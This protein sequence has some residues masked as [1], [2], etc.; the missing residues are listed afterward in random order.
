M[1]ERSRVWIPAGA[2][3]EFSSPGSTLSRYPF[4]PRVTAVARKRSR[5]FCQKCRWQVTDKHAYTFRMWLCMKWHG[6]W[7]YGVH[8]TRRDGNSFMYMTWHR[9]CQ[10]CNYTT[11]VDIQKRRYE[12]L[13]TQVLRIICERSESARERR[14]ALYRSNHHQHRDIGSQWKEQGTNR[15]NIMSPTPLNNQPAGRILWPLTCIKVHAT[16]GRDSYRVKHNG[17][18]CSLWVHEA[19]IVS[20]WPCIPC[21]IIERLVNSSRSSFR[22]K[23][24]FV[25]FK[26]TILPRLNFACVWSKLKEHD[27]Q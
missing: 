23:Q 12:K 15:R 3:G 17:P 9:P 4:H 14:T 16:L 10:R 20:V 8:R 24:L 5:S 1:I 19:S 25:S 21:I 11:L 2:A 6:A 27:L 22:V 18:D 26:R 7:L 13:V